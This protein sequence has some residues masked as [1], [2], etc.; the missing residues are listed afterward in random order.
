MDAKASSKKKKDKIKD[1]F[2][3]VYGGYRCNCCGETERMFLTLDHINNDGGN[4]RKK[5]SSEKEHQQ[6][7]TPTSG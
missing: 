5:K 2:F 3:A 4:F 7:I 6:V 1:E